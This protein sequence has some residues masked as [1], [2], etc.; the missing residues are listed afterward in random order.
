M[1][2]VIGVP[3]VFDDKYRLEQLLGRGGMGAVYRARDMRLDRLVAVKVVRAEL[4]N[5]PD[6]RRR[7][8]REAQIVARLQHPGIVAIF[9][10]GTLPDGGAY[11]VMELVIGEDLRREL[12]REGPMEPERATRILSS[13]CG[14]IEAAHRQ[15]I[16]HRDLKPENIL[17]P[18]SGL[19]PKVVD[20]G[21]AKITDTG[22]DEGGRTLTQGGTIIGTPAYMAPEQLRGESVDGR[23]DVY[24]LAVLTYETLTG[25]LPFGAGS[26]V[27]I[28]TKQADGSERV[29]FSDI[30]P[31][32]KVPLAL[33]LSLSRER[34]PPSA[35]AF[36]SSMSSSFST[37][38]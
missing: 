11:L 5:D 29:D 33:A 6:A 2:A 37:R 10:Y 14:A 13:V 17:L 35:A 22:G 9:D 7:F 32:I 8:R 19:G 12:V 36:A 34:R 23:A 1:R 28:G 25:R 18:D 30:P 20:F 26:L 27:E 4:I 24:S 16:L 21:V 31:G 15:G 38:A 3:R